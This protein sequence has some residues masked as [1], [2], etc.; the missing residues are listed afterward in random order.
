M[1]AEPFPPVGT[2]RLL[3][4]CVRPGDAAALSAMMTP[5]VS[6]WV[7]YWPVPFT[8]AMA[9]RR[10]ADAR[11][12]AAEGRALPLAVERRADG[13]VLGWVAV[14]RDAADPRRGTLGYWLGEAHQGRGTMREAAAAAVA[15]GFTLLG[16]DV[17]EAAAH[18]GNAASF[19]VMRGC[20]MA[21][22]GERVLFAPARQRDELCL[23]HEVR[24][25]G[26]VSPPPA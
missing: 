9:E 6:R 4:R 15:A 12:A 14:N 19:A 16:L 1:D 26:A 13:A 22:A 20:G 25:P 10:I 18:P 3:L 24:R 5:A 23:I 7:A 2:A 11:R 17:I 8:V 21:P